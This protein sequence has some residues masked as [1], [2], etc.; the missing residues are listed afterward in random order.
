VI[1]V[2]LS[3]QGITFVNGKLLVRDDYGELFAQKGTVHTGH[4][5]AGYASGFTGYTC[6]GNFTR[7]TQIWYQFLFL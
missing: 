1:I 5:V 3:A 7:V 2:D 6:T 4:I